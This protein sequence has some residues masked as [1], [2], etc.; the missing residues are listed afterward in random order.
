MRWFRHRFGD[1]YFLHPRRRPATL[2]ARRRCFRSTRRHDTALTRYTTS[3][4]VAVVVD[5][6]HVV[7]CGRAVVVAKVEPANGTPLR[8][9]FSIKSEPESS[10]SLPLLFPTVVARPSIFSS[11]PPLAFFLR[12]PFP[13]PVPPPLDARFP[14]S[15]SPARSNEPHL[16]LAPHTS[17]DHAH[18]RLPL[19]F[20]KKGARGG[21]PLNES[22]LS[23]AFLVP[24]RRHLH[25][26]D[27]E[28]RARRTRRGEERACWDSPFASSLVDD[29]RSPS[30]VLLLLPLSREGA[31]RGTC[32]RRKHTRGDDQAGAWS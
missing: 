23:L 2:L 10:P 20:F 31:R 29:A 13:L 25:V 12:F 8:H 18:A 22:F 32:H 5:A 26:A 21:P 6:D 19:A 7:V 9:T 1:D 3:D 11:T 17:T 30:G 14:R 16:H 27:P 24:Q 28:E 4:D 15:R